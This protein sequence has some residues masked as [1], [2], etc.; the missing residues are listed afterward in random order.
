MNKCWR[1]DFTVYDSLN[2]DNVLE[3][4]NVTAVPR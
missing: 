2:E 4:E 1:I 3:M